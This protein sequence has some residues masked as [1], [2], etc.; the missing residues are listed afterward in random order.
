MKLIIL[1]YVV[2]AL[3]S[4][5]H[6]EPKDLSLLNNKLLDLSTAFNSEKMSSVSGLRTFGG[7]ASGGGCSVCAH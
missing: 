7:T 4:C 2:L 5:V 1:I 3:S 6:K